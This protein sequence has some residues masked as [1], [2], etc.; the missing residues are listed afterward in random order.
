MLPRISVWYHNLDHLQAIL[1]ISS[2]LAFLQYRQELIM[3]HSHYVGII[4]YNRHHF[5]FDHLHA[6]LIIWELA[7]K[8]GI[9]LYLSD[10]F[11]D[12]GA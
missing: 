4:Y 10:F 12:K 6:I 1:K 8:I 9:I 11:S 2:T 7:V 5:V 3:L